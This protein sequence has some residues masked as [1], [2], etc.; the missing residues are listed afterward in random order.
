MPE[1]TVGREAVDIESVDLSFDSTK[2][3]TPRPFV[4]E[5][6]V[7]MKEAGNYGPQYHLG[8]HPLRKA[9]PD[10]VWHSWTQIPMIEG[11]AASTGQFGEVYE[12]LKKV[13]GKDVPT[14]G[15]GGLVGQVAVFQ[16]QPFEYFNKRTKTRQRSK[17]D[18]IIAVRKATQTDIDDAVAQQSVD[19]AGTPNAVVQAPL[20]EL[21]QEHLMIARDWMLGKPTRQ[22]T[23]GLM[24]NEDIPAAVRDAIF[25]GQAKEQVLR[26]GLAQ[27]V[28]GVLVA[29]TVTA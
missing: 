6:R 22:Y 13:F 14:V 7:D 17:Y 26:A 9:D 15:M 8:V 4:A 2:K 27:D 28:N 12:S 25:G 19:T 16:F 1:E 3:L 23:K 11:A 29:E 21:S 18:S 24:A 5:V 20:G 10:L